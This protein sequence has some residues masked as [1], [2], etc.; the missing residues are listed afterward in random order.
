MFK[1][2][3]LEKLFFKPTLMSVDDMDKFQEKEMMK[4]TP[5]A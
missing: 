5:L 2:L 1:A 4:R 3:E